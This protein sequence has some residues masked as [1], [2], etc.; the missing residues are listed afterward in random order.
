MKRTT[1]SPRDAAWLAQTFERNAGM[2]AGWRMQADPEPP[3]DP[4]PTPDPDEPLGEPGKRALDAEREARK[5]AEAAV[6]GITRDF[7]DFKTSLASA[8]GIKPKDDD[9]D[10][11]ATVQQQLAA[12][13]KEAAV[14]RVAN[15]YEITDKD[16]LDLLA[17]AG[18]DEARDKLAARLA[19]KKDDPA[20]G[21]PKPDLTQGGKGDPAPREALP[22]VPR[23]AQA[24]EDA[25]TAN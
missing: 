1:L 11:L 21:T 23:M 7:E 24:F 20:P 19:A 8:L 25:L 4:T 5:S 6:A 12:I 22:G 10:V 13:Q 17:A 14:L 18:T 9:G 16:D 15:Q 3:A 2:F